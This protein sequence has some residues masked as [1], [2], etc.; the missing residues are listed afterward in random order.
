MI[1]V[2]ACARLGAPHNVVFCGF[3]AD[4]LSSRILDSDS[5]TVRHTDGQFRRG[6]ATPVK[7]MVDEALLKCPDVSKVL[8]VR[9]T[10]TDV[11]WND[12]RDV[13]WHDA[14]DSASEEH[15]AQAF[16]AEQPLFMM[17]TLRYDGQAEGHPPHHRR[18]P[19]PGHLHPS[20]CLRPQAGHRRLLV[21]RRHR[22]D[23]RPQLH[24]LRSARER[25]DVA[26]V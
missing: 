5:H 9:R 25:R 16:D 20:Q 12:D 18:L 22:L 21:R 4:S 15:E 26:D 24:R 8:V 14:V 17:Y 11:E 7:P 2:L 13:W 23:H 10:E 19:H 1:T 3:S 6:S